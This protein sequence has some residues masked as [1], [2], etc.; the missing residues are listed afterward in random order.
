MSFQLL[1]MASR[2][3]FVLQASK[4]AGVATGWFAELSFHQPLAIS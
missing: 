2:Q 1:W 4:G 3:A